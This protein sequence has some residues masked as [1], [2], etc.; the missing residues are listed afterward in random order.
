MLTKLRRAYTI[1]LKSG[2]NSYPLK[3]T[4]NTTPCKASQ[5]NNNRMIIL[6]SQHKTKN[7]QRTRLMS[8]QTPDGK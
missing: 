4:T 5:L 7:R 8:A 6:K 1:T 3:Q 2:Y